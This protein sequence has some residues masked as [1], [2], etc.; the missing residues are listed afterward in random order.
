[1]MNYLML[2]P[3][4]LAFLIASERRVRSS[5]ASVCRHLA[6]R[7]ASRGL[8]YL[9]KDNSYHPDGISGLHR[10]HGVR[11]SWSPSMGGG[12]GP[13]GG[14][15]TAQAERIIKEVTKPSSNPEILGR[16]DFETPSDLAHFLK[17]RGL[18]ISTWGTGTA[19]SVKHLWRELQDR[20]STINI[21]KRG[22]LAR[23]V[24]VVRVLARRSAK[25][26]NVLIEKKQVLLDGRVRHRG[27]VLAE[28]MQAGET[29]KQAAIRGI[30]EELD[31]FV[32]DMSQI[33][34]LTLDPKT[35]VEMKPS[36]SYPGL[37][38]SYILHEASCVISGLPKGEFTTAET[39]I[40][41]TVKRIH[42]GWHDTT[43]K[44]VPRGKENHKVG[45]VDLHG[46]LKGGWTF[47]RTTIH[48]QET[49]MMDGVATFVPSADN[50]YNLIYN[51]IG[52]IQVNGQ[53]V[54]T[55]R[56][57]LYD[58]RN[59]HHHRH[60]HG[61]HHDHTHD[62]NH[63]HRSMAVVSFLDGPSK[64]LVFHN[65]NL[66]TGVWEATHVCGP[67][68]YVGTFTCHPPKLPNGPSTWESSWH[69]TGPNKNQVIRTIYTADDGRRST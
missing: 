15:G 13:G 43:K 50:Y 31:G 28:K 1:M 64:D 12:V 22:Q 61:R 29:P 67:D 54:N 51:E 7:R 25:N 26:P 30:V 32:S 11:S 58:F 17:S 6:R 65:L 33:H 38:S 49:L 69:V 41:A 53:P 66:T 8:L 55:T 68:L 36:I 62:H 21:D 14:A 47:K 18:D 42:W 60:H 46:Y 23:T 34:Q 5:Q 9:P 44:P 45:I 37:P 19:K 63:D 40:G 56:S 10:R 16:G 27:S 59:G 52:T 20:E 35:R 24:R 4:L 57:H 2:G 39:H 48:N 3:L